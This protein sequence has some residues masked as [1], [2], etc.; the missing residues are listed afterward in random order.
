MVSLKEKLGFGCK[1][2]SFERTCRKR[3]NSL[4]AI[5]LLGVAILLMV[6]PALIYSDSVSFEEVFTIGFIT[7]SSVIITISVS[8]IVSNIFQQ[9]N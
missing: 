4:V 2:N 6:L 7:I 9:N 8:L 5:I 1:K 3:K